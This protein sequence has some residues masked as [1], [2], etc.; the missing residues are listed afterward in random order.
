MIVI[1]QSTLLI[2]HSS[3]Y[4]VLYSND[5]QCYYSMTAN[6]LKKTPKKETLYKRLNPVRKRWYQFSIRFL[7]NLSENT[8]IDVLSKLLDTKRKSNFKDLKHNEITDVEFLWIRDIAEQVWQQN[9]DVGKSCGAKLLESISCES[10][11]SN[12]FQCQNDFFNFKTNRICF[13]DDD[14]DCVPKCRFDYKKKTCED[15]PENRRLSQKYLNLEVYDQKTTRAVKQR[16]PVKKNKSSKYDLEKLELNKDELDMWNR[17]S[18]EDQQDILSS[19][20]L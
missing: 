1:L 14:E 18:L 13:D 6:A 17:L 11:G 12:K 4:F 5:D 20:E 9:T 3:L 10:H 8:T 2:K 7:K 15:L 19:L 16:K